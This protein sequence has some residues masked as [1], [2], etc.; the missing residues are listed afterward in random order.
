MAS[1]NN[2]YD[3]AGNIAEW[4]MEGTVS[5]HA[6]RGGDCVTHFGEY[7]AAIREF[8]VYSETYVGFRPSLYIK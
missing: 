2:I 4:T 5:S 1:T 7:T 8:N 3:M 6:W